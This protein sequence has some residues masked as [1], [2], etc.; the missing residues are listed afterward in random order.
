MACRP[1]S[2]NAQPPSPPR[3]TLVR[4]TP[5]RFGWTKLNFDGSVLHDGSGRASIGGVIRD[6]NGRVV[7]S[8]AER[9]EH[10]PIGIVEARALIRGLKLALDYGCDRLVVEGD[11]L[12]LVKL[13]R[14][15]STQTRIPREMLDEI[16][17]LLDSF[18]VCEVQH[19]FRE[20]NSV[21]DAM[22]REAYKTAVPRLLIGM[23]PHALWNKVAEDRRGVVHERVRA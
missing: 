18:D 14:C 15:E 5:P 23:V 22:C 17:W 7:L 12:T 13:L 10:A 20:G 8:F 6:A 21:A 1:W 16:I 2:G 4:W 19:N 11:D 3:V 9:T